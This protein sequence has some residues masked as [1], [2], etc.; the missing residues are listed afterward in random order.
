MKARILDYMAT[1]LQIIEAFGA[2]LPQLNAGNISQNF[3]TINRTKCADNLTK[4]VWCRSS[5]N[6]CINIVAYFYSDYCQLMV[7]ILTNDQQ[8]L[9]FT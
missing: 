4:V 6:S 3:I 9:I 7:T 8:T 5:E 2:I 1:L